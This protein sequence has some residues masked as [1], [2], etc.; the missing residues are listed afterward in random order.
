MPFHEDIPTNYNYSERHA[1]ALELL[2]KVHE[3]GSGRPPTLEDEINLRNGIALVVQDYIDQGS[4]PAEALEQTITQFEAGLAEAF[5]YEDLRAQD[6][7]EISVIILDPHN[8][9][10]E[11]YKN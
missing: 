11:M 5:E 6:Q 7:Y 4:T 9:Y 3:R 8:N 10:A 2:S 1:Y